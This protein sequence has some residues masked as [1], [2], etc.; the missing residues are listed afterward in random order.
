[1]VIDMTHVLILIVVPYDRKTLLE[2]SMS[3][4]NDDEYKKNYYLIQ[5][6][7]N[8]YIE[9]YGNDVMVI[10]IVNGVLNFTNYFAKKIWT[11]EP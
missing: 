3:F 1:M 11:P 7:Y 8:P 5:S 2:K 9:K 10:L 4:S 6:F